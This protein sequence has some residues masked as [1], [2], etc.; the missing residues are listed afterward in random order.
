M[1]NFG[2]LN[3]EDGMPNI[4][5]HNVER[6][7][8]FMGM[9]ENLMRGPSELA[10]AERELIFAYVSALNS[11][12]YCYGAHKA[13]AEAF[14]VDEHLFEELVNAEKPVAAG[15]RL[16]PCLSLAKK[17][18]RE[19]HR[20]VRSDIEAIIDAGWSEETAHDV[21]AIAAMAT[22]SNILV[23]GHG[24]AGSPAH[25]EGVVEALGPG[26]GYLR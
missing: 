1:P 21:L 18:A 25:V 13:V 12:G 4:L 2:F 16:E 26:G 11:C 9:A 19:A 23:S 8:P 24:V 22:F 10:V 6:Y 15:E 3:T 14:G 20:V 17:A 7:G 5:Q